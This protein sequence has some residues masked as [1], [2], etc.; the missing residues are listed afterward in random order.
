[1]LTVLQ[2]LRAIYKNMLH[3]DRVLMRLRKSRA[4]AH[5]RRI[6]HNDI[7]KHAFFEITAMIQPQVRGR[8]GA[9]APDGFA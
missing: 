7:S 2:D 4:I 6:E 5:R 3:P 1:M 9:Q 8:Q